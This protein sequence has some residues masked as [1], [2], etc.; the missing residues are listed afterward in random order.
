MSL[1]NNGFA[2]PMGIDIFLKIQSDLNFYIYI[3]IES[4]LLLNAP[5]KVHTP[6]STHNCLRTANILE[7]NWNLKN[8]LS[9]KQR[10]KIF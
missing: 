7:T 3:T 1:A 9:Q 4:T 2:D 6:D 5:Y 10:S 8:I